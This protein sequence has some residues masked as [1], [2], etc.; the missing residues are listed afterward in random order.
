MFAKLVALAGPDTGKVIEV[1]ASA[2]LDAGRAGA[3]QGGRAA[4]RVPPA[5]PAGA[6]LR[7]R[8]GPLRGRP[9]HLPGQVGPG[10]P[11]PRPEAEQDGRPEGAV[12]VADADAGGVAALQQGD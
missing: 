10:V 7:S 11:R 3:A 2:S 4:A 8:D 5:R 9:A 12:P 6:A 1:A